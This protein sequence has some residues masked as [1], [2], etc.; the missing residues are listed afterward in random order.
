M[1]FFTPLE[2]T[3]RRC[4][5]KQQTPSRA[6]ASSVTYGNTLRI[7]VPLPPMSVGTGCVYNNEAIAY[8]ANCE[9]QWFT[10]VDSEAELFLG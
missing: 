6:V 5:I 2:T 1:S 7:P 8:K 3:S 4:H 10:G 9:N